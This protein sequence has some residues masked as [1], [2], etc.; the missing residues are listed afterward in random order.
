MSDFEIITLFLAAICA[1]LWLAITYNPTEKTRI[2]E[3]VGENS[4]VIFYENN[5]P[6]NGRKVLDF[7]H[8]V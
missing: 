6:V 5:K 3:T 2:I 4:Y 7:R 8:K 1:L